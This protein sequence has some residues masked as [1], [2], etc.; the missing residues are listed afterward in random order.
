MQHQHEFECVVVIF[1]GAV[2]SGAGGY[3]VERNGGK[4][5]RSP[6][7][8]WYNQEYSWLPATDR[9]DHHL[10]GKHGHITRFI[11]HTLLYQCTAVGGGIVAVSAF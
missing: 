8:T 5:S 3:P 6:P 1:H 11:V 9:D 7:L 2:T 10:T 4:P